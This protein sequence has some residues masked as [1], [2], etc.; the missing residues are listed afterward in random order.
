LLLAR[1]TVIPK[2]QL[3]DFVASNLSGIDTVNQLTSGSI[4]AV[5]A[6]ILVREGTADNLYELSCRE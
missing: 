3:S 1:A 4:H 6:E 5:S 2:S